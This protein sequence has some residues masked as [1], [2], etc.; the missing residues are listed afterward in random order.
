MVIEKHTVQSGLV[1]LIPLRRRNA[2]LVNHIGKYT[3]IL[4]NWKASSDRILSKSN[5]SLFGRLLLEGILSMDG[6]F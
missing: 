4:S 5:V 2:A 6:I 3:Y 1:M